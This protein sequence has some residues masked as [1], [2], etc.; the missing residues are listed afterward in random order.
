MIAGIS[1]I[2]LLRLIPSKL[3]WRYADLMRQ[4]SA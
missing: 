4:S 2:A 1:P 3:A